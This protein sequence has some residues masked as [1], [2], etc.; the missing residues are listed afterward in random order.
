MKNLEKVQGQKKPVISRPRRGQAKKA[1]S[2]Q[3]QSQKECGRCG[4]NHTKP[5]HF[6]AKVKKCLKCQKVGH[7]AV[8]CRSKFVNEVQRDDGVVAKGSGVDHWFLGALSGDSLEDNKWRVQLKVS[9]KPVVFKIDTGA[10]ITAMS[11]CFFDSLTN[12][13]KLHPSRIAL[14]SPGGELQCAGHFT[15]TLTC[16]NKNCEVDIFIISDKHPAKWV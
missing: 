12:Q 1:E 16:C 5:E 8:V 4:L 6:L 9:S 3:K 13:P 15:T 7:F 10:D 11:K 2:S 14:F